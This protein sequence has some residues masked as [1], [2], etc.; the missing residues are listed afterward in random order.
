MAFATRPQGKCPQ[1][2]EGRKEKQMRTSTRIGVI[3]IAV[4]MLAWSAR[5]E[6]AALDITVPGRLQTLGRDWYEPIT[7]RANDVTLDCRGHTIWG[8]GAT[9]P[10][11][12]IYINGVNN[13]TI[14]NCHVKKWNVGI[15][16][17]GGADH[18]I[19][20][21]GASSNMTGVRVAYSDNLTTVN[22][23]FQSNEVGIWVMWSDAMWLIGG[24][25]RDNTR[26]GLTTVGRI[27]GFLIQSSVIENNGTERVKP[28]A[29][30]VYLSDETSGLWIEDNQ[31]TN[32]GPGPGC[33]GACHIRTP[34]PGQDRSIREAIFDNFF[35]PAPNQWAVCQ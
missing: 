16:I 4:W 5:D 18:S 26:T 13:V 30:G 35:T 20:G 2:Q 23:L 29:A 21:G 3:V 28:D 1:G 31:F 7:I 10:G 33:H 25:V 11:R 8:P 15:D 32:N 19:I 27:N 9:T 22:S 24:S 17:K 34:C 6:V 12:G 14:K